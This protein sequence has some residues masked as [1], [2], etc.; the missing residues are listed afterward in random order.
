MDTSNTNPVATSI[1]MKFAEIHAA[2][3][4]L[5]ERARFHNTE[6]TKL[7]NTIINT[8][9]AQSISHSQQPFAA[10][11]P[12]NAN[13]NNN[14]KSCVCTICMTNQ[15]DCVLEPCMHVCC[16]LTCLKQLTDNKC[17]VCRTPT[18]FYLKLYIP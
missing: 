10:A 4:A 3:N 5:T 16:C 9:H 2:L 17:P 11:D 15:R 18:E 14:N 13:N 12:G 8:L 1:T 6:M 7:T